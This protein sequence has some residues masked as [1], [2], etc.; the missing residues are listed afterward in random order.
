VRVVAATNQELQPLIANGKFR[1]DLF[2]RLNIIRL[3]LPPLRERKGDVPLLIDHF[4]HKFS[5]AYHK[6]G[7]RISHEVEEILLRYDYP[8]NVRELENILRRA[9]ILCREQCIRP[10][11]LPTE[12][13]SRHSLPATSQPINFHEAKSQAV[14]NFERTYLTSMLNACGG[15]VS[16]A[17]H[18]AG[19][20]ERNFHE[21]L[22][23]YG[24][25]GK[26]FRAV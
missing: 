1:Q 20:S 6:P 8:G 18:R 16:R 3:A 23:K 2:Y 19:L 7:L 24:I 15:I 4:I 25:N 11:H 5:L 26:N 22:K 21:K 9:I 13:F 10:H 12:V 14:E 17:A